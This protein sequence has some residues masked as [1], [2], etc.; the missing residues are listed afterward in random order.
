MTRAVNPQITRTASIEIYCGPLQRRTSIQKVCT[1]MAFSIPIRKVKEK[2]RDSNAYQGPIIEVLIV[3]YLED[4]R[5]E[6]RTL[7]PYQYFQSA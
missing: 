6:E 4:N 3:R 5:H 1:A 2:Y 7:M